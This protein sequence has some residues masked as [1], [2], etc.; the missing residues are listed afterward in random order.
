MNSF[1]LTYFLAI[2][3]LI[4]IIFA[5]W[6]TLYPIITL[7]HLGLVGT[8]FAFTVRPIVDAAMNGH[9]L[10]PTNLGWNYYNLGL[11]YQLIFE[12]SFLIGYMILR[13][14]RNKNLQFEFSYKLKRGYLLSIFLGI[15]V[16]FIM[17][18]LS[19]GTWLASNRSVTITSAVPFGKILF[20]MSIISLS[21]SFPLAYLLSYKYSNF[22]FK[23]LLFVGSIISFLMLD[24]LYERGFVISGFI[25]ILFFYEKL[26]RLKYRWLILFVFLGILLGT[27]LR[28]LALLLSGSVDIQSFN[29]PINSILSFFTG[30]N[31]D[32]ADV[33]PVAMEYIKEK[34]L[35]FGSTFLN[36][37][38]TFLT[39]SIRHQYNL[40]LAV[41]RLNAF[42]WGNFYW[43]SN[44][45]FNVSTP[46]E[47]IM[48]FGA[49]LLPVFGFIIGSMTSLFDKW[50]WKFNKINIFNVYLVAAIFESDGNLISG[51]IEWF[52]AFVLIGWF[53]N[54]VSKILFISRDIVQENHQ[55][56]FTFKERRTKN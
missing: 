55:L 21:V 49:S 7:L 45:G 5:F 17:A 39:P 2:T 15:I 25:L 46:Q 43:L 22:T 52:V 11:I 56:N 9:V 14:K 36:L 37:P 31:F 47:V 53:I 23:L 6:L 20:P 10:Y 41:D 1:T 48:N 24:L 35:L 28:P 27:F 51:S 29:S 4:I 26:K 8:F 42:Y 13:Q 50:L 16:V 34:G 19:H 44:F 32:S 18:I 38:F 54:L 33:W 40:L 3:N 12:I 30:A